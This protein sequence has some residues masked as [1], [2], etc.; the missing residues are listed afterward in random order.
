[1][2]RIRT[3]DWLA[4]QLGMHSAL[5]L[6]G[7][8]VSRAA[9]ALVFDPSLNLLFIRRSEREGDPW[10]GHMA[11]PGGRMEPEDATT[12]ATAARETFEEVGVGLQDAAFLGP[13]DELASPVRTGRNRLVISPFVWQLQGPVA[14]VPNQEVA[15][16]HWFALDRLL[17]GEGRDT[18]SFPWGGATVPLPIVRL[19]GTDI[20]GITLRIL[21]DLLRRLQ[22]SVPPRQH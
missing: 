3:P 2:T 18:F 12:R 17:A 5:N 16:T 1:M 21:E 15:Q 7:D 19:D 10:S 20:W 22:G 4:A 11:F 8:G 6:T 13:L 14:P 9:V